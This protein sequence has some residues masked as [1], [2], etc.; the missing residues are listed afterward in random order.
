MFFS[1]C[2]SAMPRSAYSSFCCC[3]RSAPGWVVVGNHPQHKHTHTHR[4][5]HGNNNNNN[6]NNIDN[7]NDDDDDDDDNGGGGE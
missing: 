6:N 2:I 1:K 4:P 3:R 5:A 7:N